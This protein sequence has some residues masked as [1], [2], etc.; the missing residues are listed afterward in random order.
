MDENQ[1]FDLKTVMSSVHTR[2]LFWSLFPEMRSK[3]WMDM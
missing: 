2:E 3:E 1:E